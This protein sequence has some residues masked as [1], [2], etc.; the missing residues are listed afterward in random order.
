[1]GSACCVPARDR[2]VPNRTGSGTGTETSCRNI[3]CSP[4]LS[5][6]CD[7]QRCLAGEIDDSP[8]HVSNGASTNTS[9]EIEGLEGSERDNFSDGRNLENFRMP[10]SCKSLV[11]GERGANYIAL[12]SGNLVIISVYVF[13]QKS[14]FTIF[15]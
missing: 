5:F 1:M 4:T 14:I 13:P 12:P 9:R 2:T 3:T 7:R 15:I 10:I 8:Y 11:H 6:H